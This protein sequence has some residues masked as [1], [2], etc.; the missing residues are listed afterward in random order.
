MNHKQFFTHGILLVLVLLLT[1]CAAPT[2]TPCPT[3]AAEAMPE[4]DAYRTN[5]INT[6]AD[7]LPTFDP[8]DRMFHAN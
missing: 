4:M 3:T 6:Q 1:A 5:T 7:V 2:A 8:G